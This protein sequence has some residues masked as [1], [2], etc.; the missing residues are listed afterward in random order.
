MATGAAAG[1]DAL[2]VPMPEVICLGELLVD[3]VSTTVD[4]GIGDCPSF[5]KAPG[6][7]P[8]N[9]AAGLAKLGVSSGFIGKVG[10]DPFGEFLRRSMQT[11]GVDTQYLLSDD[12]AR[13]TLAFVATRQDGEKEI[14]FYRNP[15]ADFRLA[16]EEL[17]ADYIRTARAFHYGSISLTHSPARE[18]TLF[19]IET[20]RNAGLLVSYDPNL[21]PPLWEALDE[22]RERIWQV[23]P[24]AH[25]AKLAEEEWEFITGTHD[26]IE[27]SARILDQGISLVVMTCGAEGCRFAT[28]K[29]VG[30]YPAFIMDVVDPLGAGDGFVAGMLSQLLQATDIDALSSAELK[31][32]L[33]YASAT[34]A[35]TTQSM[36][37][38][39]ALPTSQ[40]VE[41]FL[42]VIA[43][44]GG[45]MGR[46]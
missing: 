30:E 31:E 32:I 8:A 22:C 10:A 1:V 11:A 35:L 7:A 27:G 28:R 45:R 23:M 4:V 19:A 38:I 37:V 12:E 17:S 34:G 15:G 26:F 20:A 13:T 46:G 42:K 44:P 14:L 29:T 21:R 3:F 18:A 43:Q 33:R 2:I 36:G 6:G 25:I 39:P 16:K 5:V 41:Q 40:Q 9:V 24:F